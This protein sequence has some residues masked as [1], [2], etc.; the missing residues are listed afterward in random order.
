[1]DIL[2]SAR[3]FTYWIID[4]H[5][6]YVIFIAS[7][8]QQCLRERVSMLRSHAYSL[9]ILSRLRAIRKETGGTIYL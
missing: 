9:S 3:P 6:E 8:R 7:S 5:S 1:M 4:T 2:H